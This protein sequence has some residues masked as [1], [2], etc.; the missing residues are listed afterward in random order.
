LKLF[1]EQLYYSHIVLVT[2]IESWYGE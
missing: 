2:Y 1:F